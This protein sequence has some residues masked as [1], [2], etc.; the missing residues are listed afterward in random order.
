MNVEVLRLSSIIKFFK[1]MTTRLQKVKKSLRVIMRWS[2][3][4][5]I[6]NYT[7]TAKVKGVIKR[8]SYKV[9]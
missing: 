7:I 9:L 4:L 8:H 2:S 6:T 5:Q 1:K 3:R